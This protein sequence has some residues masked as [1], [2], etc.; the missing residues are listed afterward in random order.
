VHPKLVGAE[1]ATLKNPD[2]GRLFF[3]DFIAAAKTPG[4]YLDYTWDKPGQTSDL[5]FPKRAFITHFE[6]LDWYIGAS[7][8]IDELNQPGRTLR[9]RTF[10]LAILPL[11]TALLIAFVLARGMTSPLRRLAQSAKSIEQNGLSVASIPIS[12]PTETRELGQVL[13]QMVHSLRQAEEELRA[14]NW[15]LEAFVGTVSHDLRAPLTPIIGYAQYLQ[16]EYKDDLDEQALDCL[17]EIET[18][19]G[20][21]IEQME[22]ML[23]LA[24]AGYLERPEQPVA[25]DEVVKEAIADL[26]DEISQ[27]G[28][29]IKVSHLPPVSIPPSLLS[30]VFANLIGNAIRYAGLK[31]SPIEIGGERDHGLVR[32]FVRDHGPGV[33]E[34]ERE[35]IFQLF[36]RGSTGRQLRGTGMGLAIVEKVAKTYGGRAWVEATPGGGSTF[37]VEIAEPG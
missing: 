1:F 25:T 27:S 4:R 17:N 32:Y 10:L 21:M 36:Q 12:G 9:N 35:E 11:A 18:Q 31:G 37:L 33:P 3:E 34:H 20:R 22:D 7:M 2:T 19:G 6:P 15:E 29:D 28:V 13:E 8:Y 23:T 5:R 26:V 24:K 16:E 30:Q 14:A